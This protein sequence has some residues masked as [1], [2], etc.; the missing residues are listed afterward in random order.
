[1]PKADG[2]V[3]TCWFQVPRSPWLVPFDRVTG[4]IVC[5]GGNAPH[6]RD[7]SGHL[8]GNL[9][10][11]LSR[12][13]LIKRHLLSWPM[14]LMDKQTLCKDR[15]VELDRTL[16]ATRKGSQQLAASFLVLLGTG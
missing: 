14:Y 10:S 12:G 1:V 9:A 6:Q 5:G 2:Y 16:I 11:Q 7:R 15:R 4:P 13:R 8:N 3:R